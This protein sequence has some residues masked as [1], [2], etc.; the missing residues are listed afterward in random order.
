M[1]E[2]YLVVIASAGPDGTWSDD[3]SNGYLTRDDSGDDLV[4][5]MRP[6]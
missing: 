1:T 5:M 6:R 4:I 2:D 3:A